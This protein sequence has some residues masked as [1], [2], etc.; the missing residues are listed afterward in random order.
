MK[1]LL[2]C[3]ML[4]A[5]SLAN[6][7]EKKD[8][9]KLTIEKGTWY[10]AGNFS[11]G[12]SSNE[13]EGSP[14]TSKYFSFNFSPKVGYTINDNLIIGLGVGY[15]YSKS[16]SG[17][18]IGKGNSYQIFPYIKK[19]FPLGKKLTIS[20]QGE[21]SYN[22]SEFS[23]N[24]LPNP[25]ERNSNQY[26]IGIRPGMTYFLNKN[27]ALEANIGS[28]G[29]SKTDLNENNFPDRESD[30]FQFNI[31]STDLMFGLSYYW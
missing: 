27:I 5:F 3:T 21:F 18:G 4:F 15:G 20:L 22:Y 17:N 11:I 31:N 10:T 25:N 13:F 19:H 24:S 26:F 28:L 14:E 7:Q 16:E 12:K 30:T 29:Y 1:K 2:L 23:D 9:E 6:A 8:N